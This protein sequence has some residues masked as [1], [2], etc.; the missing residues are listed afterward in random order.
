MCGEAVGHAESDVEAFSLCI[1][2]DGDEEMH[3][4]T[5]VSVRIESVVYYTSALQAI[6]SALSQEI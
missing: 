1:P 5:G 4:N 6:V 3:Q 2:V